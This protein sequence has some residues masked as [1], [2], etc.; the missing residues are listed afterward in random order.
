LFVY[1]LTYLLIHLFTYLFIYLL[2]TRLPMH[3]VN[4]TADKVY[5]LK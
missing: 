3:Q 1:L 5:R 4:D 2:Y